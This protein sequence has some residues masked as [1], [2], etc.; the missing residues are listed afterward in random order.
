MNRQRLTGILIAF[1]VV[2]LGILLCP[3]PPQKDHINPHFLL[4]KTLASECKIKY[5]AKTQHTALYNGKTIRFTA[6]SDM[7][8]SG[9]GI[10]IHPKTSGNRL[11]TKNRETAA[12]LNT[13]IKRNYKPLVEGE[14]TIAGRITWTLRL[15]PKHKNY[16]WKQLWIDK[17]TYHV[18]ASRDWS[19]RNNMK[20]SMKTLSI[21]YKDV[22]PPYMSPRHQRNPKKHLTADKRFKG[23]HYPKYTPAGFTIWDIG[24]QNEFGDTHLSFTDGL[25]TISIIVGSHIFDDKKW[26]TQVKKGLQ[27]CSQALVLCKN[28]HDKRII[29]IADLPK[30]ELE[31]IA[32]SF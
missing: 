13:L 21:A 2:S 32:N 24:L 23:N 20:R 28:S 9:L 19:C 15:K 8:D 27:D 31:K 7:R 3:N 18:L 16:P 26:N 11:D 30:R 4:N 17:K 29:V 22:L 14:D 6:I 10:I 12:I 25:N 1:A 5:K